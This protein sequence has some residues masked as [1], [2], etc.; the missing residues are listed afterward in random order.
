MSRLD[1]GLL[2]TTLLFAIACL[3]SVTHLMTL[4]SSEAVGYDS[5]SCFTP[6]GQPVWSA[7]VSRA[8]RKWVHLPQ[9]FVCLEVEH[10]ETWPTPVPTP[11]PTPTWTVQATPT[12]VNQ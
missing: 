5:L 7:V 4:Q 8:Q 12:P 3:A 11:T 1:W 9:G 10:V 2:T 6:A